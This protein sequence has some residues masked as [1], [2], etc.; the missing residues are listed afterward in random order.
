MV[1]AQAHES[2]LT[3]VPFPFEKNGKIYSYNQTD[4]VEPYLDRF[5]RDGL[6]VILSI[7]PNE[8]DVADLID[9]V[10]SRYGHHKSVI[11][12]NIDMEWKLTGNPNH[13]SNKERD[14]WLTQ[15]QSYNPKFKLFLTNFQDHTY[16]P[17]DTKDLV[18]LYDGERTTQ[19]KLMAKYG[20]LAGYYTS[21]GIYTGYLSSTPPTASY[22]CIMDAAPNTEYILH[23]IYFQ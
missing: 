17:D 23:V 21:V 2:K 19:D 5:D 9:I 18:I 14:L 20:E 11:G 4:K 15:I 22:E 6:K 16:F 1:V 3:Y 10:L 7:Q 12:V 8:V 13:A